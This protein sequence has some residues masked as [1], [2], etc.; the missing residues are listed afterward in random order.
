VSEYLDY[1]YIQQ[2]GPR[3][4]N[5]KR[6]GNRLFQFSCVYCG[7]SSSDKY[8]ARGFFIHDVQSGYYFFCHNCGES[9]PFWKF[10][11]HQD[12]LLYR[13]YNMERFVESGGS[14]RKHTPALEA[15]IP[16][17][18]P[19]FDRSPLR[20]LK[21]VVE[22]PRNHP[23]VEY[24]LNRKL[25]LKNLKTLRYA[26]DYPA[27]V[28]SFTEKKVRRDAHARLIIPF[29]NGSGSMYAL[30]GRAL[31]PAVEPKYHTV[32]VDETMPKVF[33]LD[34]MRID[35]RLYVVEGPIDS[36]FLDNAIAMAGADLVGIEPDRSNTT[37]VLDNEP[38]NKQ[39]VDR[40]EDWIDRGYYVCFWPE[41]MKYK[42]L[43]DMIL[44]GHSSEQLKQIID[45]NT[46][47]GLA[48][49]MRL[50]TWKRT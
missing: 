30:Q 34:T 12:P 10:L 42:D 26:D 4:R 46:Y 50:K 21:K 48:A 9:Q 39:I 8:K 32:M 22:L 13:E 35:K 28:N 29:L 25:P 20:K 19:V 37:I 24:C 47:R 15:T 14:T 40:M 3:L 23:A 1:K 43:N 27:W 11:Q 41:N 44:A 2:V 36:M 38:R 49:Q 45:D 31:D 33:G 17:P 5:F 6:K 7:D 16:N 18:T